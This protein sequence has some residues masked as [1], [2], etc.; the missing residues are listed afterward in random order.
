[1]ENKAGASPSPI[2]GDLR[3]A[4]LV[5]RIYDFNSTETFDSHQTAQFQ[6]KKVQNLSF[7]DKE[8]SFNIQSITGID[9]KRKQMIL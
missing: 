1:M 3:K 4:H 7:I 2:P 9:E 6:Q 8:M 5:N